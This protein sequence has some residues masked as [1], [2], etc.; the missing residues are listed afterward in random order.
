[1]RR[2]LPTA[3]CR[4][5]RL[6][7][8]RRRRGVR[9]SACWSNRSASASL[10][11]YHLTISAS[12]L[13]K[14]GYP[15]SLVTIGD[16]IRKRRLDLG[17]FQRQ[18]ATEIGVDVIAIFNWET[19]GVKPQVHF[20][21]RIITFLGY[22]PFP[23]PKGLSA[24]LIWARSSKGLSRVDCSRLLGIDPTTL[25][26]WETGRRKPAG[27]YLDIIQKLFEISE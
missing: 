13:K 8:R 18:A 9:V 7:F 15:K 20:M 23:E 24:R 10:P 1:V 3:G 26:G 11:F 2:G 16:H 19:G 25:A 5:W 4:C 21:G 27:R 14:P 6:V 22:N 12:H 17:L